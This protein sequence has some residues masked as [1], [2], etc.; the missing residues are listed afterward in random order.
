MRPNWK[1][2]ARV[3]PFWVTK[4]SYFLK[5]PMSKAQQRYSSKK[6]NVTLD[7]HTTWSESDN[8]KEMLQKSYFAAI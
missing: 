1:I 7:V 5:L 2:E 3:F 6:R 4:Q 8:S